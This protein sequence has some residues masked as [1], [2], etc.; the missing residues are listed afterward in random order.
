MRAIVLPS[1]GSDNEN[2][3]ACSEKRD[4][5]A[6]EIK[7]IDAAPAKKTNYPPADDRA[8]NS[9][10]DVPYQSPTTPHYHRGYPTNERT[11]HDPDDDFQMICY[12]VV[13]V[14][15]SPRTVPAPFCATMR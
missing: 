8:D 9:D 10:D 13:S 6:I 2:E 1:H 14:S 7:S 4:E 5:H 12:L 11:E 15:A 3:D